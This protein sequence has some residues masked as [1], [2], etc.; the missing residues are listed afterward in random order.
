MNISRLIAF[1]VLFVSLSHSAM[2]GTISGTVKGVNG[3]PFKGAFVQ[4]KSKTTKIT[5]SVLSDKQGK[6]HV[7][8]LPAGGYEVEATAVG[9]KTD[10]R[11]VTVDSVKPVVSDFALQKDIVRW[12]DLSVH[13]AQ[14]L[15]PEGTGKKVLFSK[16]MSCHGTQTKIA[17]ARLDKTAWRKAV[18]YMRDYKDGVGLRGRV[19]DEEENDVV[20]YL[21][22]NFGVEADLPRSPADLPAYQQVKIPEP[23]DEATKIIYKEYQL[24]GPNR[25]PWTATPDLYRKGGNTWFVESWGA[26]KIARLNTV[27]G[28]ITEFDVPHPDFRTMLHIHSVI[29]GPDGNVWFAASALCQ[30]NKLDPKTKKIT[31]YK[32]PYCSAK[33]TGKNESGGGGPSELRVDKFGNIWA[34]GGSFFRFDPKTLKFTEYP[35]AG[36]AYG[37]VLDN[38][39][40]SV[41]LT[42]LPLGKIGKID[43]KTLKLTR[44]TTPNS[45]RLAEKNKGKPFDP[46]NWNYQDFPQ[47]AGPRRIS[48]DSKGI[49]WFGEYLGNQVVSFDPAT[50]KFKEYPLPGP[51]GTPYGLGVD[52]NDY[53]WYASFNTDVLGRLDP[54]TGNVVEFPFPH[55][56]NEIRE[57]IKDPEG[58]MWYG[59]PFNNK[60]GYFIPPEVP[61]AK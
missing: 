13:Q 23:S 21:A 29:E 2:G 10:P 59:S 8:D 37:F 27:T 36:S 3:Q 60:V 1:M 49:I 42:Q 19:N 30:L 5:V 14:V 47:S 32:P 48:S 38:K 15:F 22:K 39:D 44:W 53:I 6:Y 24:P 31:V 43:I 17:S 45:A 41:Y 11:D 61:K 9:F 58:R 28:D 34:N 54:A 4:A 40:G 51:S 20:S 50:E 7:P 57:I 18:D 55:S 35:D 33:V 25:T 46:G 12:S 26:N 52:Q 16:C 56:G